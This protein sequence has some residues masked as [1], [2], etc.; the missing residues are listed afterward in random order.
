MRPAR[1]LIP[2]AAAVVGVV[3]ACGV[4]SDGTVRTVDP[5]RVPHALSSPAPSPTAPSPQTPTSAAPG[6]VRVF[7]LDA[8]L[9]LT[10]RPLAAEPAT[11]Q[12][13]VRAVLSRLRAG[14]S[15]DDRA[16]GLQ[17]ALGADVR[18]GAG[19]LADG[20]VTVEVGGLSEDQS[21]DRLPLAVG[22]VV[23]SLTSVP[24]LEGVRLQRDGVDREVP[25]P[26]GALTER[27]LTAA[28]Y[29]SLLAPPG[30]AP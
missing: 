20:V 14:P 16:A 28:D 24:G 6:P 17:S 22:Q 15:D 12:E 11:A 25:L 30:Q 19:A 4:P 5:T 26:G 9:H 7:L 29:A 27:V 2:V 1:A 3:A 21:A 18:L 13:A 10:G 8:D 23:L